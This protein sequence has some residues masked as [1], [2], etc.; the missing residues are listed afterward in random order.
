MQDFVFPDWY[1]QAEEYYVKM[2]TLPLLQNW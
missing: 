1:K 2:V